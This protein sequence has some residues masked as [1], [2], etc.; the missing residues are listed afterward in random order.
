MDNQP[1]YR[2]L[3][4]STFFEDG[5]SERPLVFGTVARG[6]LRDD[7][8]LYMGKVPGSEPP[9]DTTTFP[10]PITRAVLD[11][12][13]ERFNIYCSVCHGR[14]GNGDGMV[15]QRGFR[16]P[17]SYHI[18]RLREA[19]VGHLFDV[20]TSGFGAMPSYAD[21]IPPRDRWAIV[22]YIRALQLSQH[23]T[24]ADVPP[25]ERQKLTAGGPSR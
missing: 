23:A 25:E 18:D 16:P 22:A 2:P 15:A 3:R 9:A 10:F 4:P 17:P 1:K 12:G 6:Y 13:Q 19:P 7:V 5:Q 21:Q 8:E 24:L 20:M 14:L 11:R